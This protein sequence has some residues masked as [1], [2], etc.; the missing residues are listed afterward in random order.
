MTVAA[1]VRAAREPLLL[2]LAALAAAGFVVAVD[3][4]GGGPYPGCPFLALTGHP[5]PLC[6]GLRAVHALGHGDLA[7]AMSAN[8]MVVVLLAL[9]GADWARR[10]RGRL[11]GRP[12][13]GL[14]GW[15]FV[16]LGVAF[17]VFGVVRNVP[18]GAS[19]AP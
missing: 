9:T 16:A 17:V 1:R 6:G 4:A 12:V 19:L 3:P 5:C 8:L 14:P 15:T 13:R 11:A 7:A 2:G 10:L 18:F